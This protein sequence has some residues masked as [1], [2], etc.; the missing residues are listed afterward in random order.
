M[1]Y[2]ALKDKGIAKERAARIADGSPEWS[3]PRRG[4]SRVALDRRL[5]AGVLRRDFSQNALAAGST[6]GCLAETTAQ[7]NVDEITSAPL[8]PVRCPT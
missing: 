2:E 5:A 3:G 8:P 7:F 1:Q 4:Q 6:A